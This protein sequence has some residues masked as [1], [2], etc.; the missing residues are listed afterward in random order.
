MNKLK[1][2]KNKYTKF[3]LK[4][5]PQQNLFYGFF[6]YVITGFI[7]LSLPWLQKTD[8]AFID[9]LFTATSAVS[10]TGLVTVSIFDSYNIA[11]QLVIMTL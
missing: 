3:K 2:W 9:N 6:T 5:S 1:I 11:G 7:L 8:V 4:L 10:T